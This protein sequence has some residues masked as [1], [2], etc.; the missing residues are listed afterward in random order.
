[1]AI[2]FLNSIESITLPG[3]TTDYYIGGSGGG[4][5]SNALKIGSRT[6]GNTIA[7][8]LFHATNPV[9]LGI[10]YSGGDALAFIDSVHSSFDSV[11]QFKTGGDE[12]FRVGALNANTFQIKPAAA[13]NDVAITDNSGNAILYSDTS[14]QR[15]GIGTTSPG[16][17]LHISVPG[18]SSQ[19]TLERTGGGAGK[20]VLA[21]AAEGLIVY[22]DL[23]G[24]KMY[25]GTSGTYN[26][27]VGI[28][29][30][31]PSE[32][33]HVVGGSGLIEST[34]YA[35]AGFTVSDDIYDYRIGTTPPQ[36][37]TNYIAIKR[38]ASSTYF[39]QSSGNFV[40]NTGLSEK[41]RITSAG[42]VGIG[43]TSPTQK[44]DVA[45]GIRTNNQLTVFNT[46]LSKQVLKVNAEATTNT[47]ILKLYNGVNWGLLVRGES[48]GP[49][50][51]SYYGGS[52]NITGFEDSTGTTTSAI[53][54]AQFV[55]G[56]TGGGSGYLTLNGDLRVNNNKKIKFGYANSQQNGIEWVAGSKISAAITPVD[57]ANFS[58]AGLGFF[59]GDFSDGTTNADERMR[60]TRAGN[61]GIGTT[62]PEQRLHISSSGSTL[63]RITGGGSSIAG[64]DFGDSTNTDDGRIRYDNS[65]RYMQFVV[66]DSERMRITSAGDTGIGVTTPRAKLDVAGGIK[67]ADDTDTAGANKVGTLRYRYVPGSPKNYSYVDMCM[68]TGAS[69]YAWVNIVQNVWN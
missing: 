36:I 65:S 3:T 8:E 14:T 28:G 6:T 49:Y 58:R 43:T 18:G 53:K 35:D 9:S 42:N 64:I 17:K 24:P 37:R 25:V 56:G 66:A 21:G 16:T 39:N 47:G 60:I 31:S 48:N 26:G 50:I 54:L 67:V 68:Q 55:F 20:V 1:M 30:T 32:K 61:V 45:G 44:L 15:I 59:T 38:S 51:G 46:D 2:N 41:M 19:L 10:S 12:R 7:M 5:A 62:S 23:Y 33:L 34:T 13:G 52:F 63:M 57:T 29:T 4:V 40:W 27:N 11:L 69:S 22:D